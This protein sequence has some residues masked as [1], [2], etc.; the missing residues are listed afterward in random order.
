MGPLILVHPPS[1]AVVSAARHLSVAEVVGYVDR[2]LAADERARVERHLVE[3][4]PCRDE[5]TAC[6]RLV[7]TVPSRVT[8]RFHWR[9]VVPVAAAVLAAVLLR[10]PDDRELPP[11]LERGEAGNGS[12]ILLVAPAPGALVEANAARLLWRSIDQSTG[13]HVVVKDSTG[14]VLWRADIADT[15]VTLPGGL[16]L[17]AGESYVWRVDGQRTD[18]SSAASIETQFRVAR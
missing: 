9:V 2:T 17:R 5:V 1:N 12:Q 13:Y 3:C 18:G 8:R 15:S 4:D 10:R 7:D 16:A 14:A 11:A 6:A